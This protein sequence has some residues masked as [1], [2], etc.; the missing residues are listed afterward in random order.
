[1]IC[2]GAARI[3]LRVR[4]SWREI[5]QAARVHLGEQLDDLE[6]VAAG[7]K[8][9]AGAG[10][11]DRLDALVA[12]GGAKDIRKLGELSNVSGFLRSGRLSVIV[13]TAP[14]TARRTGCAP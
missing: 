6:H 13:R 2:C 7:T 3:D 8:I 10:D 1:M 5:K 9:S 4:R 12:R 11:H 14:A